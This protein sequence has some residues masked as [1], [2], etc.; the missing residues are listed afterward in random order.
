MTKLPIKPPTVE[1]T[2]PH[3]K[4]PKAIATPTSD[5]AWA[6]PT[7]KAPAVPKGN[8]VKASRIL[9][10][11]HA[12]ENRNACPTQDPDESAAPRQI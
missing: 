2:M 6:D 3:P 4:V 7:P 11:A 10:E 1:S 5:A 12:R 9:V 8:M